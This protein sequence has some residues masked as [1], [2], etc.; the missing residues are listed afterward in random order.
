LQKKDFDLI[1]V[2]ITSL[3]CENQGGRAG[4]NATES[5]R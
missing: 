5:G 2:Y 3:G 1:P 4:E